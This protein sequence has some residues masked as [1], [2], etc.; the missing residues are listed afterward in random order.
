MSLFTFLQVWFQN[1]RARFRR[2]EKEGH[3]RSPS[4]E[5]SS[6]SS[7]VASHSSS[8]SGMSDP[9]SPQQCPWATYQ[10]TPSASN[11]KIPTVPTPPSSPCKEVCCCPSAISLYSSEFS[12]L[13]IYNHFSATSSFSYCDDLVSFQIPC[14]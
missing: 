5:E 12:N 14:S 6:P 7:S 10:Q 9:S 13:S 2:Q 4:Y 3:R 11:L 1:R 8:S